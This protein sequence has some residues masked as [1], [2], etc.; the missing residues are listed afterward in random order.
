MFKI[1]LIT[2]FSLLIIGKLELLYSTNSYGPA[3]LN[4]PGLSKL[5]LLTKYIT[6]QLLSKVL[7][8]KK[9]QK[10]SIPVT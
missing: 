8:N 5:L 7:A 6:L 1:D 9:C 4:K 2:F 10:K 3:G